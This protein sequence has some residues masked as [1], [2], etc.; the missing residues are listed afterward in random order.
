MKKENVTHR[1]V[2]QRVSPNSL[3]ILTDDEC[4]CDGC[5]VV[6]LCNKSSEGDNRETVVIDLPDTSAYSPGE[7]VEV[8]AATASTVAATWWALILPTIIFVGTLLGIN[9]GCKDAGAW[10]V[11]WAFVALG[12]YDF[13]LWLFRRKLARKLTWQVKVVH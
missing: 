5:A 12:V 13:F 11:V 2:I 6:A 1:G 7:R 9:L 10:S 8:I 4:R 3:T